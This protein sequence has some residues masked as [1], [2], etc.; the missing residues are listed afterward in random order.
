[1]HFCLFSHLTVLILFSRRPLAHTVD[2]LSYSWLKKRTAH[3]QII[4]G[5]VRDEDERRETSAAFLAAR[6]PFLLTFPYRG[7]F[8]AAAVSGPPQMILP[9]TVRGC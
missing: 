7:S 3:H 5:F 6:W 8:V 9:I 1:M 2:A 4:F